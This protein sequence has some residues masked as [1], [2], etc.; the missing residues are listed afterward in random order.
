M[1]GE[2]TIREKPEW[3][4]WDDI[5]QCLVDAHAVNRA[6][7]IN[8]AHYQWPADRIRDS[9][10][11]NGTMLV[12]LDGDKVVGTAAIVEKQGH[13]WYAPGRY[14]YMCYAGVLPEYSGQGIYKEL[15]RQREEIARK[16]HYDILLLDTHCA[17]KRI[18]NIAK[19]NNYKLVRFFRAGSKDH[20]SVIM[21]K[22]LNGSP[23]SDLFCYMK[24]I[25]SKMKTIVFGLLRCR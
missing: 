3:V 1:N 5:K 23:F 24:Y 13:E 8:M 25:A 4:S 18:Q 15:I 6:A 12:A 20:Y 9:I 17:N 7:G 2:I 10:G 22:W 14:A 16:K 11:E 21:V 19:K